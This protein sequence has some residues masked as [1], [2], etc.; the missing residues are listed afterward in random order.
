MFCQD[1]PVDEVPHEAAGQQTT[2]DGQ[3]KRG[4]GKT[5]TDA[6][7]VDDGLKPLTQDGDEGQDKH[8]VL[9]GPELDAAPEGVALR[10]LLAGLEGLDEL[11]APLVL[12]LVDAQQGGAHEGDDDGGDDAEGA[13]PD[14]LGTG[15]DVDAQGVEGAD[16]AA[17]DAQAD[18]EAQGDADPDLLA[19]ALVGV[20][21]TLAVERLLEEGEQ[22]GDDDAG[23][24]TFPEGDEEDWERESEPAT[25]LGWSEDDLPGTAKTSTVM[26]NLRLVAVLDWQPNRGTWQAGVQLKNWRGE[27]M[28]EKGETE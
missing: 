10:G 19:E 3:R 14:V 25:R 5:Q 22:D 6:T 4:R 7:D 12:E 8:D 26:V 23:L 28:D 21:V 20:P 9:L 1:S 13:L 15:E 16:E 2:D 18:G 11:D 24:E 17:A 27:R